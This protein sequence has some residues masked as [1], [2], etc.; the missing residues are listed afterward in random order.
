MPK[1]NAKKW[2]II[3]IIITIIGIVMTAAG[4]MLDNYDFFWMIMVG[5][6][7]GL[8]FLI[9][10]FIFIGQARRLD[11]MFNN[12]DLLVHWTFDSSQQLVKAEAEYKA[13][14]KRNRILLLIIIIF[15]VVISGFFLAFGFDDFDDAGVFLAIMGGTLLII[16]IAAL[17]APGAAYRKMKNSPPDVFVSPFSAWVM[18][19]YTQ[20]KA[21]MTRIV[22]VHFINIEGNLF[23]EVQYEILQRY[24]YQQHV[25]HIPVPVG[26]EQQAGWVAQSIASANSVPFYNG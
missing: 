1:N 22:G 13:R 12:Q 4:F 18:G 7:L 6:L 15:F 3:S 26:C 20:W 5:L 14:K 11:R 16:C 9:C 17:S 23:I 2:A 10:F 25:C 8:T 21:P 24:G 19:E